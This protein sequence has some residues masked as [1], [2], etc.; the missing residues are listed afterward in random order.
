LIKRGAADQ[1]ITCEHR[2]GLNFLTYWQR[3]IEHC[4]EYLQIGREPALIVRVAHLIVRQRS[5]AKSLCGTK[6]RYLGI[7]QRDEAAPK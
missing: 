1:S 6:Y 4:L 2:N 3:Q 5:D 7:L